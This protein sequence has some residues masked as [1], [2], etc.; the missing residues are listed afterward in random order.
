MTHA[1]SALRPARRE[2]APAIA[3]IW[4]EGW[5]D[6][7]LASASPELVAARTEASFH[8][9]AAARLDDTVVAVVAGTVAGFTMVVGDELEQCYVDRQFRGAGV[10]DALMDDAL[11]R[12]R[13][14]G[15][16]SAW[17]AVVAANARA[18][19]FYERAGWSDEGPFA[20]E[21]DGDGERTITVVA[22]R[23]IKRFTEATPRT[24]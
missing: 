16:E 23:Y 8:L 7:H 18:R 19:R 20:Y 24:R 1:T 10:A 17:L 12:I 2:D 11:A 6:G 4:F 9:R 21:A 3:R 14:A 15:Y 13:A 22:H 5:R